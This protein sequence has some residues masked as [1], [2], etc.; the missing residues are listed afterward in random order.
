[1]QS[2]RIAGICCC[3]ASGFGDEVSRNL[4]IIAMVPVVGD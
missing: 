4:S 3:V 1:M 2:R